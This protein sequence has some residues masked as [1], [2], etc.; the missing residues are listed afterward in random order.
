M[1]DL[2]QRATAIAARLEARAGEA[3]QRAKEH[4]AAGIDDV[5]DD[6][7]QLA[8]DRRGAANVLRDLV[9]E[10]DKLGATND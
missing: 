7:A 4:Y 8:I 10:N 6:W 3:T 5:A 2:H 1:T 9:A